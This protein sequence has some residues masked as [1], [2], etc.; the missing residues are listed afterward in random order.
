MP[1][2]T[3][4][5]LGQAIYAALGI[6]SPSSTGQ[7]GDAGDLDGVLSTLFDL[8]ITKGI[9]D[10]QYGTSQAATRGQTFMMIARALGLADGNTT[11]EQAA[12]ALVAK[13]IVKGYNNM[14]QLGLNDP[15]REGDLNLLMTRIA[16]VLAA[17]PDPSTPS[18]IEKTQTE[19]DSATEENLAKENPAYAAFLASQGFRLSQIDDEIRTRQD[20]Y[21]E[22]ALR[23]SESYLRKTE[24]AIDGI[25]E[26]FEN[27]GFFRS[28]TRK[29]ANADKTRDIG[30]DQEAANYDAHRAIETATGSL[31]DEA[32][33][34]T[35]DG[36]VERTNA[37]TAKAYNEATDRY[38][39]VL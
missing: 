26:D 10:G 13:G 5:D 9:G 35:L 32:D 24:N 39:D 12:Q 28:G 27:R 30:F 20:L 11:M 25:N 3:R 22:D 2:A 16:P 8:G 4:G 14:G 23:R 36:T 18:I 6:S 7:F 15:I 37:E 19:L 17:K 38:E 31:N 1:N 29:Q 34:I 33:R 21:N